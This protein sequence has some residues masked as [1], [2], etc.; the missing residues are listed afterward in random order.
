MQIT[1]HGSGVKIAWTYPMYHP[2]QASS[3]SAG[4]A[5]AERLL[6]V[7]L[8]FFFTDNNKPLPPLPL[9]P[10]QQPHSHILG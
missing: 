3:S 4:Q 1:A 2:F 10:L 8:L 5:Q 7:L 6:R 9:W